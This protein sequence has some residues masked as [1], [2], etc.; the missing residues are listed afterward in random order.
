[1]TLVGP[2][3]P[4]AIGFGKLNWSAK[5]GRPHGFYGRLSLPRIVDEIA[6]R[7][8]LVVEDVGDLLWVLQGA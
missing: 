4:V 6:E 1:M 5:L 7:H 3:V 2:S 8:I